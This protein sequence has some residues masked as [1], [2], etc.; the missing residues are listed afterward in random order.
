V[1]T[2]TIAASA[3]A[4]A[5]SNTAT[6]AIAIAPVLSQVRPKLNMEFLYLKMKNIT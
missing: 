4:V 2:T 6:G 1:T 3:A 5:A